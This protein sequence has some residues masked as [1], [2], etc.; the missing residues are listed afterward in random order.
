M[1]DKYFGMR[2]TKVVIKFFEFIKLDRQ[3]N[4][5]AEWLSKINTKK[6]K[7]P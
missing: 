4:E 2:L 3:Q 1:N 7:K 5:L 6:N